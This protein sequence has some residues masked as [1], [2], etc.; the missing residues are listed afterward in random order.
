MFWRRLTTF[1][2]TLRTDFM[3]E[4]ERN[5]QA[6]RQGAAAMACIAAAAV[7][8]PAI[9]HRAA[10]QREGAEW[11]A[12]QM[13]FQA[14]M[15]A[16]V[17]GEDFAPAA[18]IE[19][20]SL[21][22]TDGL[23]ARGS[24]FMLTDSTDRRAMLVHAALRGPLAPAP[25]LRRSLG[26]ET[27]NQRELGCLAQA[28]YY[29]ARGESYR[30]QVAVAEV[31]MNRVA[32]AHYPNSVCG[33]VYQGHER[34]NGCQFTFTCDGSLDAR[35]HGRGWD[36]AQNIAAQVMLG[37]TRQVTGRATHYHTNAVDPVWNASLV[38]TTRVGD[39]IFYRF[40]NQA[41]R[42]VLARIAHRRAGPAPSDAAAP[43]E[44]PLESREL[45]EPAEAPEAG[46]PVDAAAPVEGAIEAAAPP[47]VDP[48]AAIEVAT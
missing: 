48:Q 47:S 37:Y 27:L 4:L 14:R 7:A 34:S 9:G 39:H 3:V 29:E 12:R 2:G 35:P 26:P 6:L 40:P 43:L 30:G 17:G 45:R 31:V 23:R 1:I 15:Q 25:A 41:E 10:E 33:V 5:P 42:A 18:R 22:S 11:A 46:E 20:A 8:M 28:I 24:A 38:E 32:S 19:L 13:A 21:R 16:Q 44:A 36:R